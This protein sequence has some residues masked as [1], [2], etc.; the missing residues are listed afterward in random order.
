MILAPCPAI[1]A[2]LM[3]VADTRPDR[4]EDISEAIDCRS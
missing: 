4:V 1:D 2:T 3:G